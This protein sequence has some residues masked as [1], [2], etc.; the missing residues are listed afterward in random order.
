MDAGIGRE[1]DPLRGEDLQKMWKDTLNGT[2]EQVEIA[3]QIFG[4]RK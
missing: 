1:I 3:R 2:P 4:G